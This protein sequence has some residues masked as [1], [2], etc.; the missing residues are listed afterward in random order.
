MREEDAEGKTN[1]ISAKTIEAQEGFGLPVADIN[2]KKYMHLKDAFKAA[3]AGDTIIVSPGVYDFPEGIEI[4]KSIVITGDP[5]YGSATLS[6]AGAVTKP[7]IN[8]YNVTNGGVQYHAP[9]VVFDN[10]VFNV[11]EEATGATWNVSAIGYYYEDVKNREGLTVTNCDF[12]NNSSI[13]MSAIAANISNY[14]IKGN[15]FK[16]FDTIVHSYVD[17]GP[18]GTVVIADNEYTNA[19]YI[20]NVYWGADDG[21]TASIAVTDNKSTDGDVARILIDN[22]GATKATPVN[23]IDSAVVSGNDGELIFNNYT[24]DIDLTADADMIQSYAS[25][26]AAAFAAA[27]GVTGYVY[28]NYGTP[29]EKIIYLNNGVVAATPEIIEVQFDNKTAKD[30][31]G[32]YTEGER[33]YNINLKVSD[34]EIINRLNSVDLTFELDTTK[35]AIAYDIIASN[36]EIE[37][38]PVYNPADGSVIEGRYEFHYTGKDGVKTDTNTLITIGQVKFTGYGEFTFAVDADAMTN[39]AHATTLNDNIVETYFPKGD[40]TKGEGKLDIEDAE[41]EEVIAIAKR[42]LT[43]KVSFPNAVEANSKDY[44][45]MTITIT[46]PEKYIKIIDLADGIDGENLQTGADG[47]VYYEKTVSGDLTLNSPYT[48]TVEGAGYR[49]VKYTVNM[50]EAKKLYFWNNVR[51]NEKA[52]E[53]SESGVEKYA[54]KVTFLAG[55]IVKDNEINVYD[56]SAVVSYFGEI[57]LD[58][59]NKPQYAKYDLNRDG[60]I[61][62]KDVAYVLVSWGN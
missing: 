21:N 6:A 34:T 48:V 29:N 35:G 39:E 16:N 31:K 7:V 24:E 18:L 57:D 10:L 49:T 9:D 26:D 62:S 56:L 59:D 19:K 3:A 51:D 50:T 13:S 17:H 5:S 41:I 61:D 55:D 27:S 20:T 42:D 2:G 43:I 1:S 11:V 12:I 46:G 60:K 37:I 22:F 53:V 40:I 8:I 14:T 44:Q 4:S 38:N 23:A 30:D 25:E 45:D 54:Q 32:N 52:V 28:V 47:V 58:A 33:I 15:T 36:D